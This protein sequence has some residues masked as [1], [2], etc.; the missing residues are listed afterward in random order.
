MRVRKGDGGEAQARRR[1]ERGTMRGRPARRMVMVGAGRTRDDAG[2]TRA[3]HGHGGG[4]GRGEDRL[5]H[6]YEEHMG[7]MYWNVMIG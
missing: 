7:F 3:P 5:K 1:D 6:S 2:A 4:G